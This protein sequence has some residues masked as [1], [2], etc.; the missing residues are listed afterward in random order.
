MFHYKAFLASWLILATDS[1][2]IPLFPD[3]DSSSQQ[4]GMTPTGLQELP[5]LS[6]IFAAS[7]MQQTIRL[8]D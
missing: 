6:S 3:S 8:P 4:A 1:F 5:S 2:K 7:G